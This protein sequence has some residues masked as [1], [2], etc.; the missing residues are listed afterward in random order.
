MRWNEECVRRS[1]I[2]V[3]SSSLERW[4]RIWP[5][6]SV[7][8]ARRREVLGDDVVAQDPWLR[9]IT[10]WLFAIRVCF[11]TGE[12]SEDELV[13]ESVARFDREA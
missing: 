12:R 2:R 9:R 11:L 8:R 10:H 13:R 3:G 4:E 7:G 1:I 6:T 5:L